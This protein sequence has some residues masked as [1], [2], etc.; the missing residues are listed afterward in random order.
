MEEALGDRSSGITRAGAAAAVVVCLWGGAAVKPRLV[1][2][3][4][5]QQLGA[6]GRHHIGTGLQSD[7][8]VPLQVY[9]YI[10]SC[11]RPLTGGGTIQTWTAFHEDIEQEIQQACMRN[12]VRY[13]R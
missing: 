13:Q 8:L 10:R 11:G 4:L 5:D 12:V 1:W 2:R 6:G 9:L 7:A 3:Q